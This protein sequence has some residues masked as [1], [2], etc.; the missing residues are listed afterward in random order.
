[1]VTDTAIGLLSEAEAAYSGVTT[2][3][4]RYITTAADIVDRARK[5]N[6]HE[7]LG[8]ALRALGGGRHAT[9]DNAAAKALLDGAVRLAERHR[10]PHRLGEVL[11]SRAVALH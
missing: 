6:D 5:A 7:A 2:H 1:M 8:A 4:A 10:L 3:P 9:F 11:V